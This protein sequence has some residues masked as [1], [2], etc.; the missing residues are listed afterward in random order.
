M[1]IKNANGKKLAT[2]KTV[3]DAVDKHFIF[4]QELPLNEWRVQHNLG[5]FPSVTVID[6][7]GTEVIG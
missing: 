3:S 1:Y 4:I 7:A 6:S 2:V 5:K